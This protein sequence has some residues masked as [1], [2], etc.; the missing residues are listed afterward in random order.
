MPCCRRRTYWPPYA[1]LCANDLL[2]Q[3]DSCTE[4]LDKN[5]DPALRETAWYF[6]INGNLIHTIPFAPLATPIA[7][8][9]GSTHAGLNLPN[10]ENDLITFLQSLG[11]NPQNGD[12]LGVQIK[13]K[14]CEGTES[15]NPSN[16]IEILLGCPFPWLTL[17]G[18]VWETLDDQCWTLL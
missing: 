15:I 2:T 18:E 7:I 13:A 9:T 3:M 11:Q 1:L 12:T 6:Y 4:W 16:I 14:N 17:S 8:G 10:G 5:C